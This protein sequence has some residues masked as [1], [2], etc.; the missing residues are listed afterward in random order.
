MKSP[1]MSPPINDPISN[2]DINR[3]ITKKYPSLPPYLSKYPPGYKLL[4]N[5]Q[6]VSKSTKGDI[7]YSIDNSRNKREDSVKNLKVS[8]NEDND[9]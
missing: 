5:Y 1:A 9:E 2:K 8:N 3:L 6:R 4:L 7:N